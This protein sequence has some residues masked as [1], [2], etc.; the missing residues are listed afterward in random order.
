MRPHFFYSM[1]Y[2]SRRLYFKQIE[3]KRK[4]YFLDFF[5]ANRLKKEKIGT[6]HSNID[7]S[8]LR[9]FLYLQVFVWSLHI[10][11]YSKWRSLLVMKSHKIK[12]RSFWRTTS[13]HSILKD[14]KHLEA[15]VKVI[16]LQAWFCDMCLSHCTLDYDVLM[17]KLCFF[18]EKISI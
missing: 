5:I 12:F 14:V 1:V 13:Q 9:N 7:N 4:S 8:L 18:L 16:I 3:I 15:P 10:D 2:R 17:W 11:C 6:F